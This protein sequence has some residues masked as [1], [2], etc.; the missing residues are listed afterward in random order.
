MELRMPE[1]PFY[2]EE[3]ITI[4]VRDYIGSDGE[5]PGELKS[6]YW[7]A[8]QNSPVS[9]ADLKTHGGADRLQCKGIKANCPIPDRWP[10]DQS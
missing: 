1:C 8:D 2:I 10:D 3:T 6:C 7:C 5:Y 4:N 9:R